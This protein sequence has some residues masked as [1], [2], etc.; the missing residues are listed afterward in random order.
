MKI[1]NGKLKDEGDIAFHFGFEGCAGFGDMMARLDG[2][3]I[4]FA[5]LEEDDNAFF[6]LAQDKNES[7]FNGLYAV[8]P[9]KREPETDDFKLV[10]ANMRDS[11]KLYHSGFAP[12]GFREFLREWLGEMLI[13]A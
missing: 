6:L 8:V 7:W 4:L 3:K 10:R 9:N 13:A 5:S 12:T 11:L 2:K 1:F